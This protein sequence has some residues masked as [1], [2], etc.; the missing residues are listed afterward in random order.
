MLVLQPELLA[1][2]ELDDSAARQAQ[3]AFDLRQREGV[4]FAADGHHQGAHHRQGQ[5]QFEVEQATRLRAA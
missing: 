2:F 4:G 3:H 5:W 1:P